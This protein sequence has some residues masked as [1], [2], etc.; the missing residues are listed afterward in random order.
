[1]QGT[2]PYLGT[3]L[4]DLTMVDTAFKDFI[5]DDL[6][7]FEKKRK[8]F[9][10]MAQIQLLQS[11]AGL[12]RIEPNHVFFDWFYSI[13]VYDDNERLPFNSLCLELFCKSMVSR[14]NCF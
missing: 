9:E 4:T 7:N 1:M 5:Q 2:V 14:M 3:F 6:V 12:Y 11:S 10:L 8:E 13:R